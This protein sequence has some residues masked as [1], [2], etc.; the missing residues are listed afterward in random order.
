MNLFT[1]VNDRE[2]IQA[3][4][5]SLYE[6]ESAQYRE[7]NTQ[8][9]DG[10]WNDYDDSLVRGVLSQIPHRLRKR[11][12][13]EVRRRAEAESATSREGHQGEMLLR[14]IVDHFDMWFEEDSI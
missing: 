13:V 10:T 14:T 4:I 3:V 2:R 11:V 5:P 8:G 9:S 1:Q 7:Y 12:Y 6:L